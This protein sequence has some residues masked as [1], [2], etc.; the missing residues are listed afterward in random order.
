VHDRESATWADIL[1][2]IVEH[3]PWVVQMGSTRAAQWK[4]PTPIRGHLFVWV[5]H[6]RGNVTFPGVLT[7]TKP[8][9]RAGV[10]WRGAME[11]KDGLQGD[12][13]EADDA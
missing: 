5:H 4:Q 2:T 9:S 8:T 7:A 12:R 1:A 10:I 3:E 13:S 11:G 6:V